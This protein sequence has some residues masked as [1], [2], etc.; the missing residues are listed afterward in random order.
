VG[1]Q[2]RTRRLLVL[3]VLLLAA[4]SGGDGGP[5]ADGPTTTRELSGPQT[6]GEGPA[7]TEASPPSTTGGELTDR[8]PAPVARWTV[9]VYAAADNNIEADLL[10]NVIERMAEVARPRT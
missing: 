2:S 10:V 1:G 5:A 3:F 4:C 6:T 7:A 9:L 8:A